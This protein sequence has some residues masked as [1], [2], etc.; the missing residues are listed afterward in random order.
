MAAVVGVIVAIWSTSHRA[1]ASAWHSDIDAA[2]ARAGDAGRP[3]F[4]LFT[5]EWCGAC[6]QFESEV[7]ENAA[8]QNK[9]DD[10]V[11]LRM[12]LTDGGGATGIA[13]R[14]LNVRV[15]PTLL[16]FD[17][18]GQSLDLHEG[19]LPAPFFIDWLTRCQAKALSA[20]VTHH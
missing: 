8:V 15:I 1:E 5:A 19:V 18:K 17:S 20:R 6:K 10:F 13:A 9:L 7:L 3:I 16:V 11:L 4:V 12:D 14:K 2:I